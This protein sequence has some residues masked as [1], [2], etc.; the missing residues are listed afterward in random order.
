MLRRSGSPFNRNDFAQ[1]HS[2]RVIGIAV[3]LPFDCAQLAGVIY[4]QG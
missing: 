1:I 3:P 4:L 2:A